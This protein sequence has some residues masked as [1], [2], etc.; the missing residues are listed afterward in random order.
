VKATT[1]HIADHIDPSRLVLITDC[2][3][4]VEGFDTQYQGFLQAMAARGV[5]TATAAQ[6]LD[7]LKANAGAAQ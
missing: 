3:S 5:Q 1:E 2:M 4:P 6:M 7:E